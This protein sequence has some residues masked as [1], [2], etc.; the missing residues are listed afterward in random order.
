MQV[1]VDSPDSTTT[2]T[3]TNNNYHGTPAW[4]LV[5]IATIILA[6]TG[7]LAVLNTGGNAP[8]SPVPVPSPVNPNPAPT[9]T[10]V[11]APIPAGDIHISVIHAQP[12]G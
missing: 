5:A 6:G 8:P 7:W 3:T 12:Q 1:K 9:P 11:P 4:V 10:P 2:T